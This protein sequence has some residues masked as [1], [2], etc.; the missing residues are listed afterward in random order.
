MVAHVRVRLSADAALSWP[1]SAMLYRSNQKPLIDPG[2]QPKLKPGM[3]PGGQSGVGPTKFSTE[4]FPG[5]RVRRGADRGDTS[6]CAACLWRDSARGDS[7]RRLHCN[8][9]RRGCDGVR[10]AVLATV[11]RARLAS[12]SADRLSPVFVEHRRACLRLALEFLVFDG[13]RN[14]RNVAPAEPR[15]P[16][17]GFGSRM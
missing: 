10:S 9:D 2:I 1:K 12:A 15:Q 14:T 7:G 4:E 8:F 13:N 3:L 11:R 17:R 6:S 16:G 5:D